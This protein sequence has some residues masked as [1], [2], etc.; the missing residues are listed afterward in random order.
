MHSL[1][2]NLYR[3]YIDKKDL[4][5]MVAYNSY[6]KRYQEPTISEGFTE[7]LSITPQYSF[8]TEEKEKQYCSYYIEKF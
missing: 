8:T 6:I 4:V 5:P 1:H 2:Y 3:Y 7:V